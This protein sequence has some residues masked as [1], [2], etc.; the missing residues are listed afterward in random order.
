[1]PVACYRQG[2]ARGFAFWSQPDDWL[3]MDGILID[4]EHQP[5]LPKLYEPYFREITPLEPIQMQRGGRP[6]RLI[7]AYLCSEQLRPFPFKY[8]RIRKPV[9]PTE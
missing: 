6:F 5:D 2:D 9:P 8:E 1:M 7:Q 3:G 4:P